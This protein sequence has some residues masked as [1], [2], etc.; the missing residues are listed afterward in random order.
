MERAIQNLQQ[1]SG[2]SL[3]EEVATG[4]GHVE[5]IVNGLDDAAQE[6]SGA[7]HYHPARVLR[8][9]A[10]EEATKIL[11]LVDAVR[12][13]PGKQAERAR[14]LSYFYS[15]LAK[16]IYANVCGWRPADFREV[17]KTVNH[18]RASH[19]LDGPN[20]VDW[21]FPNA[22]TQKRV[23]D[24]YVGYFS[25]N[26]SDAR[27]RCYWKSPINE[28]SDQVEKAWSRLSSSPVIR[29][30]RSLRE[31]K[32]TSAEGLSEVA[33][34]WRAVA[35]FKDLEYGDLYELNTRTLTALE[36]R[37]LSIPAKDELS[38]TIVNDWIFP[39]WPLDLRVRNV[40][41]SKLRKIQEQ[42][43]PDY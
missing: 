26:D 31:A 32:A 6:L 20:D 43:H 39:L 24:L 41:K 38:R 10:E 23:D 2:A 5:N 1:L 42:W 29:L 7:G 27:G 28:V 9:L 36:G 13:P 4:I 19:Y 18:L 3:F 16:G 11:I 22:V 12:C 35:G 14:T 15:H 30:V 33:D 17:E 21:I 37:I 40:S 25:E 34:I 8:N